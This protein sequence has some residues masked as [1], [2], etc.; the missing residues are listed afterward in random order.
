MLA[1]DD[2]GWLDV[3]VDHAARVG[4]IDGVADVGESAEQLAQ[5]Q[6]ASGRVGLAQRLV[7]RGTASIASLR[8]SPLMNR[9]A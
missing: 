1:H 4:V 6:R 3:A 9:M 5:F 8:L 7:L 2:I